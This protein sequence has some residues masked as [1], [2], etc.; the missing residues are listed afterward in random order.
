VKPAAEAAV[1]RAALLDWSCNLFTVRRPMIIASNTP[2]LFSLIFPAAG[3]TSAIKLAR[4][5]RP[6]LE[7]AI[8]KLGFTPADVLAPF[9]WNREPVIAKSANNRVLGSMNELVHMTETYLS[10]GTPVGESMWMVN[11]SPMSMLNDYESPT[12]AFTRELVRTRQQIA[13]FN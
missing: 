6:E 7:I 9:E 4:R 13:H 1:A 11:E 2:T 8:F 12:S 10:D 3:V 5:I